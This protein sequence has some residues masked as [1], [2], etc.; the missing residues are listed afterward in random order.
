M[1]IFLISRFANRFDNQ[2]VI[3]IERASLSYRGSPLGVTIA[4]ETQEPEYLWFLV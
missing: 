3:R 1:K 2:T 4:L